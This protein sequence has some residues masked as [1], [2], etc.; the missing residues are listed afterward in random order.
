MSVDESVYIAQVAELGES[1]EVITTEDVR[2]LNGTKLLARGARIDRTALDRLLRHKLLKPIDY[3][4][5][6]KDADDQATLV[7]VVQQSRLHDAACEGFARLRS[8]TVP[9]H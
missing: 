8:M 4:T 1:R 3:T 5:R 6:V 2:A 7:T 9:A